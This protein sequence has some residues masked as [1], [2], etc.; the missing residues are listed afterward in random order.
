MH[1]LWKLLIL[2]G[3]LALHSVLPMQPWPGL[4]NA[5]METRSTLASII[6]QG[7]MRHNTEGRLQNL[8]LRSSL[9]DLRHEAPGMV[10]WLI[11]SQ[12]FQQQQQQQED[13]I[14]ITHI[15][16]GYGRIRMSFHKEWFSANISLEFDI[17][18]RLPF[19]NKI[20]QLH[21]SMNLIA[22]FWLEK[23]EFGRRDLVMGNC[24]MEPSSVSVMVVTE[25]IPSKM[26]HFLSNLRENLEKVIPHVV[27]SQ[28]CP[29]M[30]E[31][32]RQLDVKLL[33]SLLEQAV[34]HKVN[35]P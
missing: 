9:N 14:N 19:N 30:D 35:Q 11:G 17:R 28:V 6:A 16:L 3:L 25:G 20:I 4:A 31:I 21:T 2:F 18:F 34:P 24:S 32:L 27:A 13:S 15:Q 29:L 22:E 23:D 5:H 1:P 12:S 26:K 10:G 33:K 7:L 8:P